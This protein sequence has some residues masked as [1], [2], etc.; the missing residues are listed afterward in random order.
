[1]FFTTF[2]SARYYE[3]DTGKFLQEDPLPAITQYT[4]VGPLDLN[5]YAYADTVGEPELNLYEY[6]ANSPIT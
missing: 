3:P 5:L 4:Y 1:M 6:A 2:A